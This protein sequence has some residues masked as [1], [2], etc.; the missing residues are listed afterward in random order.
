MTTR[1]ARWLVAL[2]LAVAPSLRA[3]PVPTGDPSAAFKPTVT[4]RVQP[5]D[6]TLDDI[7]YTAGLIA[8]FAPNEKEAKEFVGAAD[9]FLSKSL[10]PDWR[11]AVDTTRPLLG[12][13]TLD[14]NVAASTGA[15]LV[16]VKD[17]AAFRALLANLVGRVEDK[18]GV[19][20]FQLPGARSS[21]GNPVNGYA[22]FA[23]Q[24]AYLTA[25]DPAVVALNR[26][27]TPA[28]IAAGDKSAA[29]ATRIYLDRVP[30]QFRQAAVGGVQQFQTTVRGEQAPFRGAFGIGGAEML[31]LSPML[32]LYPLAEPA[33]RDGQELTVDVRY[34]RAR[35]NLT[36]DLTLMPRAG[37]DLSR[38]V[39]AMRPA[40]SL[41]PQL[42][43]ADA[44]G[45][46]LVRVT[47]PEDIRKLLL[48]KLE[49]GVGMAPSEV[50]TWGPVVGKVGEKLLP[51]LREGEIDL[52][53]ALNG[54]GKD[55]RYRIIAGLRLKDA[56]AVEQALRDAVKS[57]PKEAQ[58][59][60][61]LDA[62]TLG[63]AKVHQIVL[64]PLPEPAKS[65]FGE[66]T[67]HIAFRPDAV[68]V[69]FGDGAPASLQVGLNARPGPSVQYLIEGSGRKL[70]PLVTKIDAEAG[71]KFKT[72]LGT[73]VDRVPLVELAIEGGSALKLHYG[74][75]LT[76]MFPLLLFARLAVIGAVQ[77][78]VAPAVPLQPAQPLPRA[79]P[80]RQAL[81]PRR[82]GP[83]TQR[84]P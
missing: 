72:F 55:D 57:L 59:V 28:Q 75:G 71:K 41:F 31:V 32:V 3:A 14:A 84:E 63:G 36:F 7:R 2:V 10:G 27:P 70:V 67:V 61:K 66:S 81:A 12:Y 73:E 4:V 56:A 50:P 35:L 82:D 43:A 15:I 34:D 23:N 25:H 65:I 77:P 42:A 60:I 46:A 16:P 74:N 52:A 11:K 83:G 20:A 44:A 49:A 6:K 30:E 19:L 79:A 58:N 47:I 13:F 38:L 9:E 24:Y 39:G 51:T 69:A 8:R 45:R 26:I 68:L 64:P 62:A 48:P 18:D 5:L 53:G 17:E 1:R 22:R 80:P 29:I 76:S 21:D 54:P 37:S 40:T 78:A 33:V